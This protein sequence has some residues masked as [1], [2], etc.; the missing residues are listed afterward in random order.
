MEEQRD[1]K[2]KI[3]IAILASL[4]IISAALLAGILAVR[5]FSYSEAVS[6]E[7]PDNIITPE[8]VSSQERTG[9][10]QNIPASEIGHAQ[11]TP[12]SETA[13][14]TPAGSTRADALS[15]HSKKPGE[16]VSFQVANMFPGDSETKYYRIRVFYKDNII[17][18]YHADI[19]PGY[20][21][22]AEV[23]KVKIRLPETDELLYDGLMRDMPES[24]NHELYTNKSTQS[25]LYYEI[26]AY[27]DTSTGN[28]YMDKGLIADFRWWVEETS[29][30]DAPKTSDTLNVCLW[31]CLVTGAFLLFI[32][33]GIRRKEAANEKQ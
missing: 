25:E 16:N 26:T 12:V 29:H 1:K 32:L 20:G 28:E 27:L 5:H 14:T 2:L 30:L 11:D 23:L 6:V 10:A 33:F 19:R 21:K 9:H 15:L 7:L 31:V 4:L 3:V 18:R 8:N 13:G 22:L 24:L 17:V